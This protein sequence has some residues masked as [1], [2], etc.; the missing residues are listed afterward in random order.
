M[1]LS[2]RKR[3]IVTYGVLAITTVVFF[4]KTRT[5]N[6]ALARRALNMYRVIR[7]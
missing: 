7:K 6:A 4:P 1:H 2:Q 3:T 5:L